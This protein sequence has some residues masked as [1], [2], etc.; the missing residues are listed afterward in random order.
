M[1]RPHLKLYLVAN[2]PAYP[3]ENRFL[4]KVHEAVRGGATCVQLRDHKSDFIPVV[5]TARR[6]R[7]LLRETPL[8]INTLNSI[9]VARASG[10]DGVY[11]EDKISYVEARRLLGPKA[12]IG[13]PVKTL[14]EVLALNHAAEV[15]YISVKVAPSQRTCPLNDIL[16]GLEGLWNVRR[17]SLKRIVVIGGQN[18]HTVEPVY[19]LLHY[20]DGIAM[21]GG[22]METDDPYFTA[23]KIRAICYRVS[24]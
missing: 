1:I 13:V 17:L 7:S 22:L 11:L 4:H 24:S 21:A 12:V 20:S 19:R 5:R 8:F 6:L 9:E 2:K 18:E 16:W 15:D 10:A 3:Q 14:Q 23:Q